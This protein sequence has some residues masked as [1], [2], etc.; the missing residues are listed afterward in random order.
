MDGWF[1]AAPSLAPGVRTAGEPLLFNCPL[2]GR[3]A[4]LLV[5]TTRGATRTRVVACPGPA[6]GSTRPRSTQRGR[7]AARHADVLRC[8]ACPVGWPLHRREFGSCHQRTTGFCSSLP[9]V[10]RKARPVALGSGSQS[11]RPHCGC[12]PTRS[13]L[14]WR[15]QR[16]ATHPRACSA[17]RRRCR[18]YVVH[19]ALLGAAEERAAQVTSL[20]RFQAAAGR[21]AGAGACACS[22]FAIRWCVCWAALC[23]RCTPILHSHT[24]LWRSATERCRRECSAGC[25][26]ATPATPA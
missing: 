21:R 1:A 13:C 6:A 20:S 16:G 2:T 18:R 4:Q 12:G 8:A 24:R 17:C 23:L 3:V 7:C 5:T 19:R 25:V 15:T 10:R 22:A 9:K 14:A 26:H 11:D